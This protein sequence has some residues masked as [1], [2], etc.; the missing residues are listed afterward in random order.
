MR[1]LGGGLIKHQQARGKQAKRG[2]HG[3]R[4]DRIRND[5]SWGGWTVS[6]QTDAGGWSGAGAGG[7]TCPR[8]RGRVSG[9]DLTWDGRDR[10]GC[11]RR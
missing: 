7:R 4:K 3:P 5:L 6:R 1:A 9:E 2:T 10:D 11:C 8:G